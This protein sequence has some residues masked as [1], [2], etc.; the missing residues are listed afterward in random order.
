MKKARKQL[1]AGKTCV[2]MW[3][4]TATLNEYKK[5]YPR[6]L[7]AVARYYITKSLDNSEIV[8]RA[9]FNDSVKRANIFGV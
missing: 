5:R 1:N 7:S 2:S 3:I 9:I 8:S 6:T 4:D